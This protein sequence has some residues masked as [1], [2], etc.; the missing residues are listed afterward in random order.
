MSAEG[1]FLALSPKLTGDLMARYDLADFQACGPVGNGGHESDGFTKIQESHPVAGRGG[2]GF[3]QWTGPRR[4]EFEANLRTWC[5]APDS[6]QANWRMLCHDLDGEY[7]HTVAALAKTKNLHEAVACFERN[8]ERAGV[9][10]M[11]ERYHWGLIALNQYRKI[12]ALHKES[13]MPMQASD[14]SNTDV[15]G[16]ASRIAGAMKN[17]G[18]F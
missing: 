16:E 18:S 7:R 12:H 8:F 9:V 11:G 1:V 13:G 6:Y 10:A 14:D 4:R 3:W 2:L 17:M 15:R 5:L